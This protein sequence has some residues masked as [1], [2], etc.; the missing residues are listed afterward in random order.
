MFVT[1]TG[2]H[3]L[4]SGGHAGRYIVAMELKPEEIDMSAGELS[5]KYLAKKVKADGR[6]FKVKGVQNVRFSI[7]GTPPEIGLL[8]EEIKEL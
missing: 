4:T 1:L 8:V 2:W 7:P 5:D 6:E 3:K